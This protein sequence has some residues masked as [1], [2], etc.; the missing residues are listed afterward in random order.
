MLVLTGR[1]TSDVPRAILAFSRTEVDARAANFLASCCQVRPVEHMA[2]FLCRFGRQAPVFPTPPFL[3][4]NFVTFREHDVLANCRLAAFPADV[5]NNLDIAPRNWL[6]LFIGGFED[7][8][9]VAECTAAGT[10]IPANPS[11]QGFPI[12]DVVFHHA[13]APGIASIISHPNW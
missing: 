9:L 8:P 6:P 12:M 3:V 13:P 10:A 11:C 7:F 2:G 1:V 4:R 5:G